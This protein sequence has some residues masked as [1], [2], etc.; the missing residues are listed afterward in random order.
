MRGHSSD[1]EC[2]M[3]KNHVNEGAQISDWQAIGTEPVI[4]IQTA[5]IEEPVIKDV[6]KQQI[7]TR[8]KLI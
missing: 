1:E 2:K 7:F 6:E 4:P 3:Q 8:D 5:C